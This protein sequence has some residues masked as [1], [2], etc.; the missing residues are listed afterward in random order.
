MDDNDF[1]QEARTLLRKYARSVLAPLKAHTD[2]IAEKLGPGIAEQFITVTLTAR[3]KTEGVPIDEIPASEIRAAVALALELPK[4]PAAPDLPFDCSRL[5]G[6]DVHAVRNLLRQHCGTR[7]G[8]RLKEGP[9]RSTPAPA[10][11]G[12]GHG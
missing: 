11:K 4:Q 2:F 6:A 5:I 10:K 9:A 12:A 1:P 8:A 7:R 3:L